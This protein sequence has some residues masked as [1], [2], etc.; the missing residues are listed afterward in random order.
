MDQRLKRHVLGYWEIVA[1][2]TATELRSYYANKYY[3]E[4]K[5]SYELVYDDD[6]L[7]FFKAKLEQRWHALK[8]LLAPKN[9]RVK[10][11]MLDV[12]C[13]EGYALAFFRDKGWDVCGFDFSSAGVESKNPACKDALVTGDVFDLLQQEISSGRKYDVVWL[14]NVLEH[15]LDPIDLL[16][17]LR[18]LVTSHG[19]SVVTVPN[20]CSIVQEAAL[21]HGHIDSAF[22]VVPPD[23]LSYFDAD[24]LRG[25]ARHTGWDCSLTLG[26][27]PVDWFLFHPGSNYVREKS[28]GKAAHR[29]R[30]Q[31]ENLIHTQPLDASVQFWAAAGKLGI[32]R[33]LT[34]FFRPED[35]SNG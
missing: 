35:V 19:V 16:Q 10:R 26:D 11:R 6:E 2:P 15:V 9:A 5:G 14:Q 32:G 13:G 23:H 21:K 34:G 22:W 31:I 27:F 4:G 25:I 20:D 12:G 30:I 33:N 18:K 7:A 29:A 24:S 28:L 3:Q 8:A 1:K 17:S